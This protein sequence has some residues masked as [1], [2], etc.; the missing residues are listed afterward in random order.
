ML[1][2]KYSEA[3]NIFFW[4]IMAE[5]TGDRHLL[6]AMF[7]EML[8]YLAIYD[9]INCTI[10]GTVNLLNMQQLQETSIDVFMEFQEGNFVENYISI[11]IIISNE[12]KI[13]GKGPESW[14]ENLPLPALCWK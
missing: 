13:S 10:L 12:N 6:L 4:F 7:K 11:S 8:P 1:W 14:Q 5:R 2:E 3:T 9:H